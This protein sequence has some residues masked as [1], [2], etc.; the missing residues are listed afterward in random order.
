MALPSLLYNHQVS[1]SFSLSQV[2]PCAQRLSAHKEKLPFRPPTY[3]QQPR[4]GNHLGPLRESLTPNTQWA[5]PKA[6]IITVNFRLYP[7]QR[8]IFWTSKTGSGTIVMPKKYCNTSL[9]NSTQLH[10]H[11]FLQLLKI[12][13]CTV[14]LH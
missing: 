7:I 14:F 13:L 5:G 11:P 1:S 10:L 9:K 12:S 8:G 3:W 6:P 4:K 2:L